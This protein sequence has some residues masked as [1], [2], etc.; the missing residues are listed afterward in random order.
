MMLKCTYFKEDFFP[1]YP[2]VLPIMQNELVQLNF[3]FIKIVLE[4]DLPV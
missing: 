2:I 4:E 3:K 1:A